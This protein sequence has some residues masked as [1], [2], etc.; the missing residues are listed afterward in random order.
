MKKHGA[1]IALV[2]LMGAATALA[3]VQAPAAAA[4]SGGTN[5]ELVR[6][7]QQDPAATHVVLKGTKV[8]DG[9]AFTLTGTGSSA[10]HGAVKQVETAFD[11]ASCTSYVDRKAISAPVAAVGGAVRSGTEGKA[12]GARTA[13]AEKAAGAKVANCYN[14][15]RSTSTTYLDDACVIFWFANP[16]TGVHVV[17]LANEVQWN[18]ANGCATYGS[19]YASDYYSTLA[20]W[21]VNLNSWTPSF[22][23]SGVTSYTSKGFY[24]NTYCSG[25]AAT[26]AFDPAYLTGRADGSYSWSVSWRKTGSCSL[27]FGQLDAS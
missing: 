12:S 26:V 1:K 14:P 22:S 8:A 11:A 15:G 20:G 23:C 24:N 3:A 10:R 6:Y 16:T 27:I 25:S 2:T 19:S 17:G 4:P 7:V 18:P 13:T 9:C 5:G 21:S